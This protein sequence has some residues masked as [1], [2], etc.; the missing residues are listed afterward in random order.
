MIKRGKKPTFRA[1]SNL[2]AIVNGSNLGNILEGQYSEEEDEDG[3]G[4]LR[5]NA[6][7]STKKKSSKKVKCNSEID[8]NEKLD[9]GE[10]FGDLE[11]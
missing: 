11:G 8:F 3:Y 2:E 1:K 6:K 10:G 7:R 5:K 4:V 9:Q